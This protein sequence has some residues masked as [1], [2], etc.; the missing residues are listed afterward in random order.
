MAINLKLPQP[1]LST[2]LKVTLLV[3]NLTSGMVAASIFEFPGCRVEAETREVA[4][5]QLQ[6][7]FLE[8]FQH[9]EAISW[10]VPIPTLTPTWMKF[11]GVFENDP[12]FAAIMDSIRDERTS[13]DDSEVDSSYYL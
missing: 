10:N 2:N 13:D 11:A 8:R 6:T 4:I 9:I 7:T 12:D 1:D 3:E 5:A